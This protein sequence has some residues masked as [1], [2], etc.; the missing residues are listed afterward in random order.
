M[1]RT[2]LANAYGTSRAHTHTHVPNDPCSVYSAGPGRGA[3]AHTRLT[4]R[5]DTVGLS[6][7]TKR[8]AFSGEVI[9]ER[10][11]GAKGG[12]FTRKAPVNERKLR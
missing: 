1:T 11:E 9:V 6:G 2:E 8:A 4:A 3:R 5:R 7:P 10:R 12:A